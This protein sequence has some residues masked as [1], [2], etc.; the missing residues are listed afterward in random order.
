MA[1]S[2]VLL[3][4]A[5]LG[6]C[7]SS[8]EEEGTPSTG[9]V[10]LEPM[11]ADPAYTSDQPPAWF[12]EQI[13]AAQLA[14]EEDRLADALE[15][16]Y[17][18]RA[19][20]PAPRHLQAVYALLQA[21]NR[22]V[23]ELDTIEIRAEPIHDPRT[24]GDPVLF[25]LRFK[26]VGRYPVRIPAAVEERPSILVLEIV[27]FDYDVRAQ[28]VTTRKQ[29]HRPLEQDLEIPVEGEA[30]LAVNLGPLG[31]GR[32]LEGFRVYVVSG[33]LRPVQLDLGRLRR[34]DAVPIA[35]AEM[36]CFRANYEH[37]ADR[38][39]ER[40]D[41][42]LEKRAAVHL[43]TTCGLVPPGERQA[44]VDRLVAALGEAPGM[45]YPV[46]ACLQ[47]LTR[48]DLGREAAPWRIWWARVRDT[49]FEPRPVRSEGPVFATD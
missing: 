4:L 41:Q 3:L 19:E 25:L 12:D 14:F 32:P 49:Y 47:Y 2:C 27:R 7:R 24:F 38:P 39:L 18:T 44:A 33:T 34:W 15:I 13:L 17:E 8:R 26:N 37:L 28:V 43:L 45:D 35:P 5:A 10:V 23:L 9:R 22:A 16:L 42:A 6:A 21:V 1:R 46:Y 40:L 11:K 29:V 31:S 20:N 30:E 36:R 48:E